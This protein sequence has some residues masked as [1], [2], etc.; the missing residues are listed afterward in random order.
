MP[1]H[2]LKQQPAG[3]E[4]VYNGLSAL[5]GAQAV[6]F[7]GCLYDSD[8]A[9]KVNDYDL[10]VLALPGI[11]P[12]EMAMRFAERV[13]G[14]CS[15][16]GQLGTRF[17][18]R[19]SNGTLIDLNITPKA[20]YLDAAYRAGMASVGLAGIAM[21]MQNGQVHVT[22]TYLRDK[23]EQTLT[24]LDDTQ[25]DYA[26]KLQGKYPTHTIV[27]ADTTPPRVLRAALKPL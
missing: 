22:T 6:L 2:S 27:A 20:L 9:R 25:M 17:H 13:D 3:L 23:A 10:L 12:A 24:L 1:L 8:H 4:T 21:D 14:L 26:L 7:G 15:Q 16:Y 5:K 11:S 18:V 19:A